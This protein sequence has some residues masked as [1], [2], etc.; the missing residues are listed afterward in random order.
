MNQHDPTFKAVELVETNIAIADD[1]LRQLRAKTRDAEGVTR[2]AYGPGEDLAHELL[3]TTATRL[4]L[5]AYTDI[6][7]NS[8][9]RLPGSDRDAPTLMTGSHLDSQPRAGNYD[10]A[11]GVVAGLT[12][13]TSIKEAGIT[14]PQDIILM[15]CRAE[16]ASGWYKGHHRGHIGS[17]AALGRLWPEELETAI[18]V[19]DGRSLAEHFADR[20]M[21]PGAVAGEPHLAD[22]MIKGF[23]E[24][25]IEQG[26]ILASRDIPVGVVQGIRGNIRCRSAACVG[27]YIHSGAVPSEHRRDAVNATAEFIHRMD[28]KRRETNA[29]G[30]DMVYATG[31]L[32][33][34]PE[35]HAITKVAGET[36]FS[37]DIRSIQE[38]VLES[39]GSYMTSLGEELG[40]RH[41]V[42]FRLGKYSRTEPAIMDPGMRETLHRGCATLGI[43]RTDIVS[44]GGHDAVEFSLKGIPSA[45]IF[46]RNE[47]GSHNPDE[48]I[49]LDDL[50]LGTKLLTWALLNA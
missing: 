25:H 13:L 47:N 29:E 11:A 32:Y 15:A 34:N 41:G 40:A 9:I 14:P 35:L 6:A 4:G 7:H 43:K 26:P 38:E 19:R 18:H 3:K 1:L 27:E 36:S 45:M 16:E 2:E 48:S 30:C 24:L 17:R 22:R 20:G 50:R 12:A 42:E 10:G 39:M 33:T 49:D 37:V 8:Y 46:I 44:G 31:K 5:E 21:D 28:T 23:L